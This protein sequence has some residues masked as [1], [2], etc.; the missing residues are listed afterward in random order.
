MKKNTVNR[1][2]DTATSLFAVLGFENVTINQLAEA[3]QVNVASISYYFG[4]K[5]SLYQVILKKQFSPALQ[6]LRKIETKFNITEIERLIGYAELITEVKH[7]QPFLNPLWRY[8]IIR[9]TAHSSPVVKDYT[10]QLYQYI[11]VSLCQGIANKEFVP[12]LQ[13]HNTASL[14]VEIIHAPCIP[15]SLTTECAP[16]VEDTGKNYAVQAFHHYLHGIRCAP[17]HATTQITSAATAEPS[18]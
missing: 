1:I 12:D 17:L 14:L 15:F 18:Q 16:L 5:G 13:P 3:A 8:E 4:G 2:I 9:S 6:A 7:K 10:F 11:F